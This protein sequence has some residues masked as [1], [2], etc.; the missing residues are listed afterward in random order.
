RFRFLPI[1][2][3]GASWNA[4][5]DFGLQDVLWLDQLKLR[6][7]YGLRGNISGLG[8][9]E[10]LAYYGN[11]TRFDRATVENLI[12]IES[13]DNPSMQWEKEKMTN[14]ALE[15]GFLKRFNFIFEYYH[16]D[17][18]DLI[19]AIEVSRAS[20]FQRKTINWAD[21]TNQGLEITVNSHNIK[22]SNFDWRTIFT[23]GY[24]K[25]T[26]NSLQTNNTILQ[27]SI[28]RGA[29]MVGRPVN[30]LYSFE[31]ARLNENGLPLFYDDSHQAT[32]R[33]D[34]NSRELGM[35]IY[36]GSREPLS[37]GGLTNTFRYKKVSLSTLFTFN[38]GNKIRLNPFYKG[39]YADIE[40]LD[41]TLANRW[42]APGHEQYTDVP[43]IIDADTRSTLLS[44]SSDPFTF[45]N[46]SH[47]RTVDGSFVRF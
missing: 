9:P 28:D 44:L 13:P 7:S 20:G 23:F 5:E 42:Q 19:S 38:Y 6:G 22:S 3:F 14:V 10:L 30:G 37:S 39:Y 1:W 25:N 31:F 47:I 16:R 40:A 27:Q 11:T 4:D 34:K 17:N 12:T 46:R 29:A 26:I 32:F 43:R 45:Y 2:V 15:F 18:Y 33:I 8:S 21:M 35:L 36:E 24:N 41:K